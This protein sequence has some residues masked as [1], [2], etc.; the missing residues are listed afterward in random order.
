VAAL[1]LSSDGCGNIVYTMNTVA[2][3][4]Y[5]IPITATDSSTQVTHATNLTL[6]VTR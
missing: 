2:P 5:V 3:G 6:V 1:L 4:T